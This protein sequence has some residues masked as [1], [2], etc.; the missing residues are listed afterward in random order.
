MGSGDIRILGLAPFHFLT[1]IGLLCFV[2][3]LRI[4]SHPLYAKCSL[5]RLAS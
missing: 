3:K 1:L 4:D 5:K 2:P